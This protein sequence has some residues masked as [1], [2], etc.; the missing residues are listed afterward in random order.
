MP[1]S[2]Q[3]H[4]AETLAYQYSTSTGTGI[5][6]FYF[7]TAL[8]SSSTGPAGSGPAH[9]PSSAPA[10]SRQPGTPNSSSWLAM[11]PSAST[12]KVV[13]TTYGEIRGRSGRLTWP[14][15][16]HLTTTTLRRASAST[17]ISSAREVSCAARA[18]G[19]TGLQ[20]QLMLSVREG[21]T[22]TA[23]TGRDGRWPEAATGTAE[24]ITWQASNA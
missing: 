14:S 21:V 9:A 13:V 7:P 20:Q 4:V 10:N 24:R 8:R 12:P 1:S 2:Y 5:L 22:G 6:F 15:S 3:C 16:R 19:Q 18:G 17:Q 11:R 23:S